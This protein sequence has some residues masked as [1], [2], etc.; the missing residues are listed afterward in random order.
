MVSSIIKTRLNSTAHVFDPESTHAS[1]IYSATTTCVPGT[2]CPVACYRYDAHM[3][4]IRDLGV[5]D[6]KVY[7]ILAANQ[8]KGL[9]DREFNIVSV[10]HGIVHGRVN[11]YVM[12]CTADRDRQRYCQLF[13][14]DPFLMTCY[15]I[16]LDRP[17]KGYST[18]VAISE[19]TFREAESGK[20]YEC[21]WIACGFSDAA[22]YVIQFYPDNLS[23]GL[24]HP[25]TLLRSRVS[26]GTSVA[27]ELLDSSPVHASSV[28]I[29]VGGINGV[30]DVLVCKGSK[31]WTM[32]PTVA[33]VELEPILPSSLPVVSF[34]LIR[35]DKGSSKE[36][37][38]AVGQGLFDDHQYSE[39][40]AA[41]SIFRLDFKDLSCRFVQTTYQ[42][43]SLVRSRILSS[44]LVP[45]EQQN[46]CHLWQCILDTYSIRAELWELC[47]GSL[48]HLYNVDL[49]K[50]MNMSK[51]LQGVSFNAETQTCMFLY[52]DDI[53]NTQMNLMWE[54][55]DGS[56]DTF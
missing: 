43:K 40:Q 14:F 52:E 44:Q 55:A 33:F 47:N 15:P 8:L 46:V 37:L 39:K 29:L 23:K 28:C 56:K 18:S 6:Y 20:V 32:N 3:L 31:H 4:E 7:A 45:L 50:T 9:E 16:I 2:T 48:K 51:A 22:L 13:V 10:E 54:Q 25:S 5:S 35:S 24:I 42:A 41:T 38:L 49:T 1:F 27:I 26:G 19:S 30:V 53:I 17:M 12:G 21:H 36:R 11:L 34:Q